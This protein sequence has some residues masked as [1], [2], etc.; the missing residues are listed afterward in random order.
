MPAIPSSSAI[1]ATASAPHPLRPPTR[2]SLAATKMYVLDLLQLQ[3][4]PDAM[5]LKAAI[6]ASI[7]Q[8]AILAAVVDAVCLQ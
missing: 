3:R 7:G 5:A 6:Q 2:R 1:A 4:D 8:Q